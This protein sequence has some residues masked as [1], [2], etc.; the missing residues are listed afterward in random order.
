YLESLRK[1]PDDND[2]RE[3]YDSEVIA[4][5]EKSCKPDLIV[6]AGYRRR[7]SRL[8]IDKYQN[9]IVNLYPGDITKPYLVWGVDAA[10]QALRAGEKE[11]KCTVYIQVEEERF[12]PALVQSHPVSLDGFGEQDIEKIQEKIRKEAEWLIF[13]FAVHHLIAKGR[14]AMDEGGNVYVDGKRMPS[15]GFQLIEADI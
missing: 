5:I 9:K 7:L 15:G 13:P 4:L 1:N 2:A 11:I 8:F 3:R 6:L 14:V 10:I 12:G